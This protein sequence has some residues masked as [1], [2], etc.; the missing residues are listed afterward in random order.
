MAFEHDEDV[1]FWTA[2]ATAEEAYDAGRLLLFT[3]MERVVMNE[4]AERR[5][6]CAAMERLLGSEEVNVLMD[7]YMA[8]AAEAEEEEELPS[9]LERT[10]IRRKEKL[11]PKTDKR[12]VG[13]LRRLF[14]C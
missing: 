6:R 9:L 5:L 1:A 10:M 11:F 13:F 8:L 7:E 12:S 3:T 4:E 2:A 14:S